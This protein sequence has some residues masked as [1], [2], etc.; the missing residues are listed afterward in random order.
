MKIKID[1][2]KKNTRINKENKKKHVNKS[3]ETVEIQVRKS[4]ETKR[5]EGKKRKVASQEA[6]TLKLKKIHFG[7]HLRI[8]P[9]FVSI[10]IY[11]DVNDRVHSFITFS[12]FGIVWQQV[13]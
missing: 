7:G 11:I 2:T 6:K 10:A 4:R 12:I 8:L 5:T 3:D 13:W 1:K 9:R